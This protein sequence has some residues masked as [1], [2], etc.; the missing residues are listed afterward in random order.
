MAAEAR[1]GDR[2]NRRED[3]APLENAESW[4]TGRRACQAVVCTG[5]RGSES[6]NRERPMRSPRRRALE[7]PEERVRTKPGPTAEADVVREETRGSACSPLR[8]D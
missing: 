4:G 6:E 7:H 5:R 1:R 3:K 8:K 2:R